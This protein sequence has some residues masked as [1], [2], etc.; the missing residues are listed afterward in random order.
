[1]NK[2]IVN[3]D[4][5]DKL[6]EFIKREVNDYSIIYGLIDLDNSTENE[7]FATAR[8]KYC[9]QKFGQ[10]K[11]F[12]EVL[13]MVDSEDIYIFQDGSEEYEKLNW[14]DRGKMFWK[15]LLWKPEDVFK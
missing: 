12:N 8:F 7:L 2:N 5:L 14:Y 9:Y 3:P 6:K 10:N 11:A 4:L 15:S 13:F 1:M